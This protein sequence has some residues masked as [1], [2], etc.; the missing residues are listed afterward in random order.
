[1]EP[2]RVLSGQ[3]LV[4]SNDSPGPSTGCSPTTPGPRTLSTSPS[5]LVMIHSRLTSCTVSGP[6]LE[7][8]TR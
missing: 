6:S 1:M 4:Y 2:I 3:K 7:M 5:A 8:R